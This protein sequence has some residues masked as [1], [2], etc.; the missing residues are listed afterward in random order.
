MARKTQ[1]REKKC[2]RCNEQDADCQCHPSACKTER[3]PED[4]YLRKFGWQ[5]YRRRRNEPAFWVD[6]T[7]VILSTR[8]ALAEIAE[9][10]AAVES[11][12]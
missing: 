2:R 10:I 4:I 6:C 9:R 1:L 11:D 3:F 8:A 12:R 5:I 7:R